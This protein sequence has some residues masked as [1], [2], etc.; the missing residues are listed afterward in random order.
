MTSAAP[1]FNAFLYSQLPLYNTDVINTS[2][3]DVSWMIYSRAETLPSDPFKS[4]GPGME[5]PLHAGLRG[6]G[7]SINL[8][9]AHKNNLSE[10]L[11]PVYQSERKREGKCM[12]QCINVTDLMNLSRLFLTFFLSDIRQKKPT[13]VRGGTALMGFNVMNSDTMKCII[14]FDDRLSYFYRYLCFLKHQL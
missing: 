2:C 9:R 14:C 12:S 10:R 8:S 4:Q 11:W 3:G 1:A 13:E 6:T 7:W 5:E